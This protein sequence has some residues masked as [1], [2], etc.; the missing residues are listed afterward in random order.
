MLRRRLPAFLAIAIAVLLAQP[1]RAA[2]PDYTDIWWAVG[3]AESGWGVTLTQSPDYLFATFFVYDP[4]RQPTWYVGDLVRKGTGR[5]AGKLYDCT[6]NW[7]GGAWKPLEQSCT[8]VG[9]AE[10]VAESVVR[11]ILS[12]NVGP[13]AVVKTIERQSL[14]PVALAGTYIGGMLIRSSAQCE[15]GAS[16]IPYAYQLIVSEAAGSLVRIDQITL[17][18]ETDCVMQGTAQQVGRVR[19]MP[20]GSYVCEYFGVD[21]AVEIADMRR[22]SNGGIELAWTAN[23]GSGCI[24]TGSFSGVPQQ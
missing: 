24:E 14:T 23:L 3:G 12:Y 11:G 8:T 19:P 6:G 15:G 9:D 7:F 22:T 5:Y 17:G 13:T 20:S 1:A 10:F 16:A 21:T 4:D 2:D 18:G